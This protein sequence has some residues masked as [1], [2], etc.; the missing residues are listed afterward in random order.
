MKTIVSEK[1]QITIPK[2]ICDKMGI[3][4]GT[5]LEIDIYKGKIIAVKKQ[6]VD[7]F[8]KWR[9]K[10]KLPDRL[11]VDDYLCKARDFKQNLE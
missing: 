10:G 2:A 7:V 9:G 6:V 3:K 1:G 11:S 5:V 4:A 8:K